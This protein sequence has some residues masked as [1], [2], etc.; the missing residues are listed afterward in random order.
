MRSIL[1]TLMLFGALLVGLNLNA[2]LYEQTF[3]AGLDDWTVTGAWDWSAD[4]MADGIPDTDWNNRSRLRSASRGGA[5]RYA[6]L[7]GDGQLT[8]PVIS[9]PA[10]V[11]DLYLTFYQY[12]R[13]E[14]GGPRVIVTAADGTV[15]LDSLLRLN[16]EPGEETSSGSYHAIPLGEVT[17]NLSQMTI[18]FDVEGALDF[19]LLDDVTLERTSPERPT[20]P[21]ALGPQLENLGRDFVVD[22]VGAPAVPFELIFDFSDAAS[23]EDKE[24]IRQRLRAERVES[25]VCDRLELWKLPGGNFFDPVSGEILGDPGEILERVLGSDS[26]GTV[27]GVDLNYL[28]FNEL[29]LNPDLPNLPLTP[30]DIDHLGPAPTD[31]IKVAILD[32]GLDFDHPDLTDYLYRNDDALGDLAD[33]DADCLVDNVIGWNFVDGNN[34]PFD[35]NSHGTHVSGIVAENL[36]ECAGCSFQLI[37][38][39]THD[40]RGV[41]SLFNTACATLH[42]AIYEE[43]AVINA[44]W[45]FYGTGSTILGNAIDTAASY[46]V[47]VTAAAGND[48]LNLVADA[49]YPATFPLDNVLAVGTQMM[50]ADGNLTKAEFTNYNPDFVDVFT[51][52]IMINST[53]PDDARADKTGTSMSTPAAAAAAAMYTCEAGKDFAQTRAYLLSTATKF[54]AELGPY[55]LDGNLLYLDTFCTTSVEDMS[56]TT[57]AAFVISPNPIE[58][59]IQ[60]RILQALP[61]AN[62]RVYD[63]AGRL[64]TETGGLSPLTGD[65]VSIDIRNEPPGLYLLSVR[66]A[67]RLWVERLVKR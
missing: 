2:Q 22:S 43:V 52:G 40:S 65:T 61:G 29:D 39:K 10:G 41:G 27:D 11:A 4:G 56:P 21:L 15:L 36:K 19:W 54:P 3:D 6:N 18:Q 13:S 37:P 7:E 59:I 66:L 26:G 30:L 51:D 14:G 42:A 46:G 53:V 49:Q 62:F 57:P 55:V 44:S 32:T 31:A 58:E 23:T 63:M 33:D 28:N 67:G 16:L 24:I 5:A 1:K 64:V 50:D 8:S 20:F 48:S 25:C 35:D 9:V 60:V 34:N 45:G 17:A 12:L 38:Y 47:L